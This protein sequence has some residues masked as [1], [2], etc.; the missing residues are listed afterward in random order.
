MGFHRNL[1]IS[2]VSLP[3]IK[4]EKIARQNDFEHI[5]LEKNVYLDGSSEF[6]IKKQSQN[7][8]LYF[9]FYPPFDLYALE[10]L[11]LLYNYKF[12]ALVTPFMPFLREKEEKLK[13]NSFKLFENIKIIT[14]EPHELKANIC[15][16][17]LSQYLKINSNQLLIFPDE[18]AKNRYAK[19]FKNEFIV[20]KKNRLEGVIFEEFEEIENKHCFIID[21]ILD[22][23]YTLKQTILSLKIAKALK[24]KAHITHV[25]LKDANWDL[26]CFSNSDTL[27]MKDST[28]CIDFTLPFVNLRSF[29]I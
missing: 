22:T 21:D 13:T 11:K 26:E 10:C 12:L 7:M 25:L 19:Y 15:A 27:Y 23:G 8:L 1:K 17:N 28:N 20:G 16:L 5:M 29:L 14:L 6:F 4:A 18:G 3:S 2:L 24:I 9:E